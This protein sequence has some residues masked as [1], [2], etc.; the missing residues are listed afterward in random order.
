MRPLNAGGRGGALCGLWAK[1]DDRIEA[2]GRLELIE[3]SAS[4]HVGREDLLRLGILHG[5]EILI[6]V[7]VVGGLDLLLRI[8]RVVVILILILGRLCVCRFVVVVHLIIE[9]LVGI[10]LNVV[11]DIGSL[12]A[13]PTGG[14]IAFSTGSSGTISCSRPEVLS[15]QVV[16]RLLDLLW[17]HLSAT[18]AQHQLSLLR[19]ESGATKQQPTHHGVL[20]LDAVLLHLSESLSMLSTVAQQR[21]LS[22]TAHGV[23]ESLKGSR[24]FHSVVVLEGGI[25]DG[26]HRHEAVVLVVGGRGS[27]VFHLL[28]SSPLKRGEQVDRGLLLPFL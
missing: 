21:L 2:T 8:V 13:G 14:L 1:G 6:V 25:E 9:V 3:A 12:R 17:F 7:L 23:E 19:S 28:P 20:Q 15:E 5:W 22:A 10:L 24:S 11:G 4:L 26:D 18:L 16:E 27:Q